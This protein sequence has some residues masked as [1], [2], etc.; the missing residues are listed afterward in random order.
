MRPRDPGDQ[1]P[2]AA[3]PVQA[4]VADFAFVATD[5]GFVKHLLYRWLSGE[6]MAPPHEGAG[7]ND[8]RDRRW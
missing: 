4:E 1:P 3:L 8:F 2:A 6:V 5:H 7:A